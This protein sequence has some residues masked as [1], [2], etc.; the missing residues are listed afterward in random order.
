MS[1]RE[2]R[3]VIAAVAILVATAI[4]FLTGDGAVGIAYL[5][6]TLLILVLAEGRRA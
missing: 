2:L 1:S 6:I 3:L 5:V 4:V